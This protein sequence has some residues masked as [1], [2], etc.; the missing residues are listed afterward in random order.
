MKKYIS[1]FKYFTIGTILLLVSSNL[2][3]YGDYWQS[4]LESDAKGYYAYLP[5]TFVYQDLNFGF[6]DK[7]EKEKYFN[8]NLFFDYRHQVHGKNVNK[9]YCGTAIMQ[10]P[11]FLIAHLLTKIS[12]GDADGYSKLYMIAVNLA[13]IFYLLVGLFYFEKILKNFAINAVN[14]LLIV[15]SMVFATNIFLYAVVD[16]GMSHIYSFFCFTIFIYHGIEYFKD[17]KTSRLFLIAFLLGLIILIRPVNGLLLLS[18]PFLAGSSE[19]FVKGVLYLFKNPLVFLTCFLLFFGIIAIQLLCYKIQV[20]HWMVYSY[21]EEGFNF[22][23]PQIFNILFSYK[24]GLFIYTPITFLAM[25]GY[26]Y[27]WK[28]NPFRAKSL[29]LFMAV[30]TYVLS[31]WW[32]WWYGGSFSSRVYLEYLPFFFIPLAMTLQNLKSKIGKSTI[33]ALMVVFTIVCQIQIWQFRYFQIHWAEMT[34]E[35]YWEVFLRVDQ[36]INK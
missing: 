8:E 7:I 3:W 2:N 20:G 9:Y 26:Y 25:S 11:F 33:I 12:G 21:G 13:A 32:N 34:K 30:V 19:Q 29:M 10:T 23:D 31:S 27:L 6:F 15:F 24:K 22:L 36:L 5:A 4:I 18:L 1:K 16:P 17:L 28:Q 35:Q 14:I